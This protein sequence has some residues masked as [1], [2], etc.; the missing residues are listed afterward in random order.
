[1]CKVLEALRAANVSTGI[2]ANNYTIKVGTIFWKNNMKLKINE[3]FKCP[4]PSTAWG[5]AR[6]GNQ[7]LD[8]TI[9]P[10]YC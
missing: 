9:F 4:P 2:M 8:Q 6:S 5:V 10:I 7:T 1:M 3:N